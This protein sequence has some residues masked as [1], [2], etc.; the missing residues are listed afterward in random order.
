MS[1]PTPKAAGRAS[2]P[3]RDW[4][5][6]ALLVLQSPRPVFAALRDES[7]EALEARQEPVTALVV[8]AGI[9]AFL[10]EP[11][12]RT[13]LDR[14]SADGLVV[15]V[16]VFL[17]GSFT[18]VALYWLG[19]LALLAGTRGLDADGTYR[20]ARHVLAFA[21]APLVLSLL[22]LWPL[23]LSLYG[24]DLFRTGG[25]DA[26]TAGTVL[27]VAELA[28]VLWSLGLV[29]VGLRVTYGLRWARIPAVLVVSALALFGLPL[30]S[31]VLFGGIGGGA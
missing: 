4:W 28:F 3:E 16:T 19:G 11:F 1:Q 30:A 20:R 26:G 22:L 18:G 6:R 8:L 29:V 17:A 24:G 23:A 10:L 15:A 7:P 25:G 2:D 12:T 14:S 21:T 31:N 27:L 13:L 9:A 5:L